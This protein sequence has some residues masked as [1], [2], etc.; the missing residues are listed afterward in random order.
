MSPNFPV[1]AAETA[2]S[3]RPRPDADLMRAVR[4]HGYGMKPAVEEMAMPAIGPTE[5]LVR[6]AAVGLN[7]LDIKFASGAMAGFPLEFPYTM[8]TDLAGTVERVGTG[9][10]DW[11]TGDEVVAR[12]GPT[13]GGAL[14]DLVVVPASLVVRAPASVPLHIA[15]GLPTAAGTAWQALCEIANLQPDQTVLVQAG[16]GGVGSFAIQYGRNAGAHVIATAS[17]TGLEIVRGLGAEHVIDYRAQDI[18]RELRDVD[19]VVDSVGGAGQKASAQVLRP[20]GL[21]IVLPEPPDLAVVGRQDITATFLVHTSDAARLR[22]VVES[23]EAGVRIL[24]DRTVPLTALDEALAHQASGS[25]RGK[26]LVTI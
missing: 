2:P 8:G 14:A 25:A 3:T 10:V 20:G 22:K 7:P 5:V 18:A 21:L 19:V 11:S 23:V 17:G 13:S 12:T 6:V 1:S 15:A 16:A 26:I 24:V 9:V 4:L